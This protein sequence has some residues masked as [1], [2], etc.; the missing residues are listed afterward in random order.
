MKILPLFML[1]ILL[2]LAC[3]AQEKYTITGEMTRD[4]LRFTPK[5]IKKLYLMG[6]V[7]GQEIA[8][9]SAE[10]VNR[11]FRFEGTA[12]KD[13]TLYS[14][15]GFDNGVLQIFLEPGNIQIKPFDAHFP[16][17]AQC[18]GTPANDVYSGY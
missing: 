3:P 14:I 1:G 10:V 2:S 5:A 9:D 11:K 17:S 13:P 12:P 15:T 4:S 8:I 7:D 16:V 18:V 6:Q